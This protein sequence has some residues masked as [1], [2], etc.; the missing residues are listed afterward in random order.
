MYV[1]SFTIS[2]DITSLKKKNAKQIALLN[3]VSRLL[4]KSQTQARPT[5]NII[6][7]FLSSVLKYHA[8]NLNPQSYP[9]IL[10]MLLE[11]IHKQFN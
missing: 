5:T 8:Q 3:Q 2:L 1:F 11:V 4:H 7:A 9:Q 10:K 6:A